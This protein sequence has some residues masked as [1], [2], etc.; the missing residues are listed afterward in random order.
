M[1]LFETTYWISGT[2]YQRAIGLVYLIAF[3]VARNQFRL[4]LGERGLQPVPAY[5][6]R[7]TFREAPSLFQFYYSDRFFGAVV[8]IGII[9]SA[10][11]ALG[12]TDLGPVWLSMFVW[13]LLW[14]LYLSIVNVGQTFYS[15]G[16]E[17]K[18]LEAGFYAIFLGPIWMEKPYV[19][20][21]LICWLLF[22]V[23]LGAGLIKMRG[24]PCWRN[25]TCML[26][27][28]ETQPMPN[29]LSWYFHH[30]PA[31]FHKSE[32][33]CNHIIQL[34]VVWLI[35]APQPVA[36]IAGILIIIS[37]L[38]LVQSGNYSWLNFMTIAVAFPTVSD[39]VIQSVFGVGVPEVE[40]APG[41]FTAATYC[42]AAL[43]VVLSIPPVKN[44]CSRRQLMNYSFNRY[45]LV[46]TYGAFGSVTQERHE[47]VIEGT[48][49]VVP[50]PDSEW[51]EYEFKGKPTALDRRPPQV[52]PYHL[53][54]DWQLWFVPLRPFAC[55]AWLIAFLSK[56]LEND[57][58]TL[59]LI[60]K[61]PFPDK[62]P[63][64]VRVSLYH[65]QFTS[66]EERKA[67]GRWWKRTYLGQYLPAS[68]RE[69]LAS[70][71]EY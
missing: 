12:L 26:Y 69:R 16:W 71:L 63:A 39:G 62:P 42:L 13:F 53:R 60:R 38:W 14:G 22:R 11:A 7:T 55:P 46:N 6:K 41:W 17:S 67:T 37:Q 2:A 70:N 35:F 64:Q 1:E 31:W 24:D 21:V 57:P 19:V 56:L 9:L 48:A 30:Q 68:D 45:H 25:L 61:N 36:S 51:L 65:Y 66:P 20:I 59:K 10:A 44:L 27:H 4:L 50:G 3:L 32:T 40:G 49:D 23:E 34:G 43:V 33:L 15:F 54:L 47:V 18:L 8:W 29:P 28:H 5:L 52:A 58:A